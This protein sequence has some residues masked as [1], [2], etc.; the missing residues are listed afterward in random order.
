MTDPGT[1]T[2]TVCV[3]V[4]DCVAEEEY[5]YL[6]MHH[7]S[8]SLVQYQGYQC[9]GVF[10]HH[11]VALVSPSHMHVYQCDVVMVSMRR[12][13]SQHG[14][15]SIQCWSHCGYCWFGRQLPVQMGVLVGV[16]ALGGCG[17]V[18][19]ERQAGVGRNGC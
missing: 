1:T 12:H 16:G 7:H 10:A 5:R 6:L 9:L 4:T 13:A 18:V 14:Y 8:D 11:Y 15:R 19:V 3:S 17:F 2:G